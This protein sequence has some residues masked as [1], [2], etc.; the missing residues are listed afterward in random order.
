MRK[1][2]KGSFRY[3]L[4]QVVGIRKLEGAG[5][6]MWLVWEHIWL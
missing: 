6:L 2:Q 5:H 3:A 1:K 4:I